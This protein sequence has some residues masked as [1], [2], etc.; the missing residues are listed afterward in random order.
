MPMAGRLATAVVIAFQAG[1][2]HERPEETGAAH[3]LEHMAFKGTEEYATARDLNRAAQHL[4]TEIEASTG[5]DHVEFWAVVRAEGAM[6]VVDLLSDVTGTA[7]MTTD[8]LESERT[9]VLQELA[10]NHGSGPRKADCLMN[11]ALFGDH[12]LAKEIAG[13]ILDIRRLTH[14]HAMSFRDRQWSSEA[15]VVAVAGNTDHIDRAQMQELLLRIPDREGRRRSHP[16]S[17]RSRAAS[18]SNTRTATWST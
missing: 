4:G 14:E 10:E 13:E 15:A 3:M 12:R 16:R 7:T 8:A 6:G 11:K 17:S 18:R 2:R 9:V 5:T 1:A